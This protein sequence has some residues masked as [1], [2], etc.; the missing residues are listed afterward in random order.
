MTAHPLESRRVPVGW[1][2]VTVG[3][4]VRLEYGKGL[5]SR[6]RRK[7]AVPVFSAAG[8]TGWHDEPLVFEPSVVLTRKGVGI[9]DVFYADTASWVIDTAFYA[10]VSSELN[11]RWL[12]YALLAANLGRLD[13][14][15]AIPSLSRD[16]V[17]AVRVLL[18]P[19]RA[20]DAIVTVIEELFEGLD[21]GVR[22][23]SRALDGAAA[24]RASARASACSGELTYRADRQW[25]H[26][27]PVPIPAHWR[28]V[29]L[30]SL[31][32]D[33]PRSFTDGPFG[34][35]LKSEHYTE[36]GPRVIR[37]QNI[38][39]GAFFDAEAH[40]DEDRF[41]ALQAHEARA[42]DVVIASLGEVLPRAC[43]VPDWL[44]PAIVKADC[45]RLRPRAD[46]SPNYL[47]HALNSQPVRAQAAGV[48]HGLGRPRLNLKELK[49]LL[50]PLPPLAEQHAI[51][52]ALAEELRAADAV[53]RMLAGRLKEADALKRSIIA[54]A[55]RGEIGG[56]ESA[57]DAAAL[58][59]RMQAELNA[60]Q[61]L[62][63]RRVANKT[64]AV[65]AEE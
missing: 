56:G 12:R 24:F 25:N 48:I 57:D 39:D 21:E 4:L 46:V 41:V 35:N 61:P 49:S 55:V 50:I 28:W 23:F 59:E 58:L 38:G 43:L 65:R 44:G 42:G 18:P 34:S 15:T 1:V 14:S 7:G 13:Q 64:R 29:P 3:E 11:A 2:S 10:R 26:D 22:A 32:A 33:E 40:I 17:E 60:Q 5:P 31:A 53:A 19:R 37:L 63:R 54:S 9:G 62:K 6:D 16:D 8:H 36:A 52:E 30:G 20:Q 51:A 45:P 27:G 47:V